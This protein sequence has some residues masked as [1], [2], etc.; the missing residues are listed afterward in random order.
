M[1]IY[2]YIS[3]LYLSLSISYIYIYTYIIIFR[4][5]GPA[6]ARRTPRTK[7]ASP[8]HCGA[9]Q[10]A[11]NALARKLDKKYRASHAGR[12]M[13]ARR[14]SGGDARAAEGILEGASE[15]YIYIYRERERPGSICMYIYIYRE[16]EIH[17]FVY[18]FIY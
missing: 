4:A 3:Y 13:G 6:E 7:S 5:P 2:I 11:P 18:S 14:I 17:L 1:Y 15:A 9:V 12:R 16:R 8:L 10:K